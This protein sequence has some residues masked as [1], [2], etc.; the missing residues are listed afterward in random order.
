MNDLEQ[1]KP[2]KHV[3]V[4]Q[5]RHQIDNWSIVQQF[6]DFGNHRIVFAE[7]HSDWTDYSEIGVMD[8]LG[9]HKFASTTD[10]YHGVLPRVFKIVV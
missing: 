3:A 2:K 7:F 6:D 4:N 1:Q 5:E 8:V 9:A 10:F